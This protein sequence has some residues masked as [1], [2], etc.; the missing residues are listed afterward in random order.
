MPHILR[1]GFG[2]AFFVFV[3]TA[4]AAQFEA[5]TIATD[6]AGGYQVVA[7]DLNQDGK[8]DLIALASNMPE[9]VWYENPTWQRHIIATGLDHMINLAALDIDGDGVPEIALAYGFSMNAA[10][11]VGKLAIL[12]HNGDPRQ[13]W[14]LK[15][16]DRLPTS[17]RLRW[18]DIDG[19]GKHVL[20]NSP[21]T[22]ATATPPLFSGHVPLVYYDPLTWKRHLISDAEEG[23]V[24]GIFLTDWDG[25]HR[26]DLLIGGFLGIHLYRYTPDRIWTR[27]AIAQG[28]P[29]PCPKCGNSDIAVGQIHQQRFLAAI[30][31]WHGN[32]VVVYR[33]AGGA[34]QREVI[35]TSILDGHTV[36]TADLDRDGSDQFI[37]GFRGKPYGVY[38]Y[39]SDGEQWNRQ[40]LDSGDMSAAACTV[41][42]LDGDGRPDIACIGSATH[43]LKWYRNSGANSAAAPPQK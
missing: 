26:D 12:H 6:L 1:R 43:N 2:L 3:I 14:T 37:I 35:D 7:C 27:T 38:I 32:Q 40:V 34:W 20:I 10:Q 31:P 24:H 13:L 33:Q 28:A 39:K 18:A 25:N 42:D 22:A 9:L 8:P 36:I 30:E 29:D 17:H 5:H 41:A 23:I 11:S 19:S 15:G 4:P 16:I 21:L